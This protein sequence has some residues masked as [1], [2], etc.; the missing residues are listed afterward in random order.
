M[1]LQAAMVTQAATTPGHTL[2][3]AYNRK[4]QGTG[5]A[6][7]ARREEWYSFRPPSCGNPGGL[8]GGGRPAGGRPGQADVAGGGG[9]YVPP[10]SEAVSP[11]DEGQCRPVNQQDPQLSRPSHRRGRVEGRN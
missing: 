3:H 9:G 5:E 8:A 1:A 10:V 4:M 2:T 6:G 7:P 11:L